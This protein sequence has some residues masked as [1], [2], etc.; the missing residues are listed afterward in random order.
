MPWRSPPLAIGNGV[1]TLR[2]AGI[3]LVSDGEVAAIG[4][5]AVSIVVARHLDVRALGS[6]YDGR[7]QPAD[8]EVAVCE[9]LDSLSDMPTVRVRPLRRFEYDLLVEQGAFAPD[10]RVQLLEGE[11]VEMSPQGARHAGLVEA[12]NERLMPALLGRYRVRVQL[13]LGAG[14]HSEPEPDLAIVPADEP[15]DRHPERA[16]LVIE[17]SDESVRLDLGRKARIYAAAGVPEYWVVDV[18][19]DVVHVH[20]DPRAGTYHAI[21]VRDADEALDALGVTFTLRQLRQA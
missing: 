21:V 3:R 18:G 19:R 16:L 10:E 11:L 1:V 4:S 6:S 12:L 17:V 8:D 9:R 13:P 5:V 20:T 14:E 2:T 7:P 15:R